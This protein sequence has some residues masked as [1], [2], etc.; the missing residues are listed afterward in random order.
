MNTNSN[1]YKEL[2][3]NELKNIINHNFNIGLK[4]YNLLKG[5]LFNTT[6]LITLEDNKKYVLRLGP[7]NRHLLM[8]FEQNL[9]NAEKYF[10]ELCKKE[11]IPVSNVIACDTTKSVLDR[12]YML[13]EYIES[14]AMS[15]AS[16]TKEEKDF[17]YEK[18]GEYAYKIQNIKGEKFGRLADIVKGEGFYSWVDYLKNDIEKITDLHLKHNI[19]TLEQVDKIRNLPEKYSYILDKITTPRL[20]H[21]DLWEG[22]I[23]LNKNNLTEIVAIIDGDRAIFADEEY[24]FGCPYMVNEHF[25]KG[26]GKDLSNNENNIIKRKI[27]F[28]I[29]NLLDCYVWFVQYNNKQIGNEIK[30][31]I[32][33]FLEEL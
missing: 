7:I 22:N 30:E 8:P 5:G 29:Y 28:V 9:M 13:V 3:E 19:L 32:L 1:L 23:L 15:E 21:C 14:I 10:Y 27:Y 18:V 24:E 4:S 12:D 2:N 33:K 20:T 16:L 11:G 25:I 6:Y 31:K 17:L 26:Y